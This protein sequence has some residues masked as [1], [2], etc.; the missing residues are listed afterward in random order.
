MRWLN[1]EMT[2]LLFQGG[3]CKHDTTIML[4]ISK[5]STYYWPKYFLIH[6]IILVIILDVIQYFFVPT[7][8]CRISPSFYIVL[9]KITNMKV[10][11]NQ[12]ITL[13]ITNL[14]K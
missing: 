4:K 11:V 2:S 14:Y 12:T 6:P 9:S 13:M 5:T 10:C 3:F 7:T 1:V 8:K